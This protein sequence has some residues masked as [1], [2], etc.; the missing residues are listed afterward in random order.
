MAESTENK[1]WGR[2]ESTEVFSPKGLP[3]LLHHETFF[4]G[5]VIIEENVEKLIINDPR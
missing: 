4:A 2:I 3:I 1:P 5:R